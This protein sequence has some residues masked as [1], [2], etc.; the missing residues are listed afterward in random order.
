[1]REINIES[2]E[3]KFDDLF[4]EIDKLSEDIYERN[5]VSLKQIYESYEESRQ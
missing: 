4:A 2:I 5:S 3:Q 1:M